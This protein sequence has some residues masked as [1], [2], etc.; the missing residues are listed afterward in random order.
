MVR[1]ETAELRLL[2]S[3]NPATLASEQTSPLMRISS[4]SEFT[5]SCQCRS[6]D[7]SLKSKFKVFM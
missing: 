6:L 2:C 5:K 1:V 7:T 4:L 3:Q